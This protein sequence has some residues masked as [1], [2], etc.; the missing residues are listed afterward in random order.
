MF[1][2]KTTRIESLAEHN[3]DIIKDLED[4][5]DKK[6]NIYIDFANIIF[7]QDK[8]G[9]HISLKRLKQ[10][11]NSFDTIQKVNFY[12]GTLMDHDGSEKLMKEIESYNYYKVITKPVKIMQLSIDA[13]SI[14][15]NSPALLEHFIIKPLLSKFT[16][17]TIESLN[18]Q[19][20]ELNNRGIYSIE[21]RKCNFDV[22][23]GVDMELDM[24]TNQCDNFVLWSGDSDFADPVN[25]LI[26]MN[27][28]VTL[29]MTARR[30][31]SELA[32]TSAKKFDIR[33]IKEF[34]CQ[35]KELLAR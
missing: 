17:E 8:L 35:P 27:K 15:L 33:K 11:F 24:V 31:S 21:R 9:W 10:F 25:K 20:K 26:S 34:I 23:M 7:W 16:L 1:N 32:D 6:T 18:K 28:R 13:S 5:F 30:L 22:E 3:P 14:A 4:I 19:L 12:Y 2:P 29:F